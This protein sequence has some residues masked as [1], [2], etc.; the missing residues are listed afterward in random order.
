MNP[1]ITLPPIAADAGRQRGD[2]HAEGAVTSVISPLTAIGLLER[3]NRRFRPA[4]W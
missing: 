2:R 1:T 4:R 3:N